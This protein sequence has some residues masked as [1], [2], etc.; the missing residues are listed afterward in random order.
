MLAHRLS[1]EEGSAVEITID[2]G[3][4]RVRKPPIDIEALI[5]SITPDTLHDLV[6][7]NFVGKEVW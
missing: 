4:L 1:F 6:I 7:D 2:S 3:A 5:D